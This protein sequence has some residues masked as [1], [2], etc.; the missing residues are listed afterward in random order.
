MRLVLGEWG[1]AAREQ[2]VERALAI[3]TEDAIVVGS[4]SQERAFGRDELAVFLERVFRDLGSIHWE[5]ESWE[6]RVGDSHAWFFVQGRVSAGGQEAP[7]RASGVCRLDDAGEW[8]LA[9]FHG[10]TPDD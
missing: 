9:L 10:S 4:G 1:R 7:Y 3:T 2:D 8:K 5:W 6:A